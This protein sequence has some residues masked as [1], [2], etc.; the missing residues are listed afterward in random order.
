MKCHMC[1]ADIESGEEREHLGRIVCEDCYMKVLSPMRTCDPWAVYSVTS[2]EK[3]AGQTVTL[4]PIQT[5]ILSIL[6]EKRLGPRGSLPLCR[7]SRT[8]LE[9]VLTKIP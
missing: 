1:G 5:K 3:H 7:G 2:F 4:T 9:E 8:D 6:A